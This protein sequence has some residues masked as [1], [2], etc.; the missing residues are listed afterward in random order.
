VHCAFLC[1][2]DRDEGRR[3]KTEGLG[4]KWQREIHSPGTRAN[5]GPW[6]VCRWPQKPVVIALWVIGKPGAAIR[7]TPMVHHDVFGENRETDK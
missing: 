2:P 5:V 6:S 3:T 7:G 1:G 4:Y